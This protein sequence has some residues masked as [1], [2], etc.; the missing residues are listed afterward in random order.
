MSRPSD[1]TIVGA[2]IAGMTAALRLLEAGYSV[3]VI[4]AASAI[5]GKFGSRPGRH[6]HYD[7]A[8][9][10]LSDWCLNFWDIAA[11][12]GLR[13]S[14]DFAP[15]PRA[16]FLRPRH[17]ASPWPR[18]ATLTQVG[19]P[20][21]FWQN[22]NAGLAHWSDVMLFTASVYELLCDQSLDREEF[23]N[24]VA[25]NGYMRFLPHM[26]DVAALLHNE[27][28]SRIWAIPSYLISARA[29]QKH[30]QLI[31]PF[32][33]SPTS[34]LVMKKSF[35]EGFWAPFLAT[36]ARFGPRFT[37]VTDARLT[38]IR[39][40]T[41]GHRVDQIAV[42]HRGEGAARAERVNALIV[43]IPPERLVDVLADAESAE[44]R[45]VLP[46]LLDVGKLR[47]Q[48]TSA[49]TLAFKRRLEL[50]GVG[51]DPVALLEDLESVYAP[52]TPAPGSGLAS[53]YAL[54][55]IDTA[56]MRDADHPSVLSVLAT[57]VDA[58]AALDP[59]EARAH[60]VD[61]L[62]RYI[63]FDDADIDWEYSL[64]QSHRRHPLFVNMVGSWE[65]RPEVRSAN[66]RGERLSGQSWRT[67]ANLYLAGDYCRSQID[68]VSLEGAIHTGIWA[69]HALGVH[70][71][72]AGRQGVRPVAPPRP[73]IPFDRDGA[74]A[75][76]ERLR[77][78]VS[79]AGRRSRLIS[80][81]FKTP[82]RRRDAH[83]EF[84]RVP[85]P[86]ATARRHSPEDHGGE[87]M[88]DA[89][90][91]FPGFSN[92]I[93]APHT[94]WLDSYQSEGTTIILKSGAR[95]PIPLL[96]WETRALCVDALVDADAADVVLAPFGRRVV[97]VNPTNINEAQP[98]SGVGRA[99]IWAP[100]YGGTCVGPVEA[101]YGVIYVAPLRT[102]KATD[103]RELPH[104]WWWWYYGIAPLND[105][106][107][108]D[109]WGVPSQLA[110]L[111][112]S[113]GSKTKEVRLLENGRTALRLRFD[114][115]AGEG[116]AMLPPQIQFRTV[117]RRA[118]DDGENLV[119]L[120]DYGPVLEGAPGPALEVH[121]GPD[122][123]VGRNLAAVDFR[124]VGVLFFEGY[125]GV[126]KIY[127]AAG[128][129]VDPGAT[130][131]T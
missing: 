30:L 27:L 59:D 87:R 127:N 4:D 129:A 56:R 36:L 92:P 125:D 122:T 89:L 39:L 26:S 78:W 28:L 124:E 72:T 102:C 113:Y 88:T 75:N 37:L 105:E 63:D 90:S 20:D 101:V 65:Y 103:D 114:T 98:G 128:S 41:G 116:R 29:Y 106:F 91:T 100:Q 104:L 117:A 60:L 12:I 40:G 96:F 19:S 25:V 31:A 82:A 115:T 107:K 84:H 131:A 38:G 47:S 6:G 22:A 111:E 18:L 15:R 108:R 73:P 121:R 17:S 83:G 51:D 57:D 2:G 10:V 112:T 94:A 3:T 7:F 61:E 120:R 35:D 80:D 99:Q 123:A 49:L 54:S 118:G 110:A 86:V 50:P 23:L 14:E 95:V 33:S 5:G 53:R 55:F 16:T 48:Q 11:T 64:F 130:G 46:R 44:L 93:R 69:A 32:V 1:V 8:W 24:R 67:I 42:R 34:I 76:R 97:H 45:R 85:R 9:H 66:A 21:T 74:L 13:Q 126:V 58:L 119:V 77:R 43:A 70:E 109:V 62:R 68:I 52:D 81:E 79:I 71:A